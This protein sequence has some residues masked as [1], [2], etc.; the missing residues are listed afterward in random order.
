[1]L[2]TDINVKP[3]VIASVS[4]IFRG[5]TREE[6]YLLGCNNKE[7]LPLARCRA[8]D[9]SWREESQ[10]EESRSL[11]MPLILRVRSP[12]FPLLIHKSGAGCVMSHRRDQVFGFAVRNAAG[13]RLVVK[14]KSPNKVGCFIIIQ[15]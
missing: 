6:I 3:V 15:N 12:S 7:K 9:C 14:K 13:K 4:E 5:A 11:M 8:I 2:P 1:L 10:Q